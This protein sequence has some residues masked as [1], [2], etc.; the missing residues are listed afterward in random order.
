M[1]QAARR[2]AL[3]HRVM[4][5]IL[6]G[7]ATV[8]A[9]QGERASMGAVAEASG[10]ARATLY[11][12]FPNRESLVAELGEVAVTRGHAALAAARVE[13]VAPL[14]GVRRAV[15]ALIEIGDPFVAVARSRRGDDGGEF[16][17][18]L[19][20]PLQELFE[21][22]Q[23]L[24]EIR[25]DI[26]SAWLTESLVGLIVSVLGAKPALGREDTIAHVNGL[27]LDG[28]VARSPRR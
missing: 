23:E 14:E 19:S 8:F 26:P 9:A 28:A 27:F 2:P 4:G 7:A 15:R 21:R 10:V 12:Y 3:Q 18:R 13:E 16:E 17:R 20:A 5:A 22:G 11:R 24:G 25:V 1:S 6:E